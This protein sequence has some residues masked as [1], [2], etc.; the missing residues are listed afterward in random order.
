MQ[1]VNFSLLKAIRSQGMRQ[2]DLAQAVGDDQSIVSRIVNGV[3]NPD[4][5]RKL[6]YARALKCKVEDLFEDALENIDTEVA[7]G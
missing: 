5:V 3:W 1:N 7:N 2:K 6:K 4:P